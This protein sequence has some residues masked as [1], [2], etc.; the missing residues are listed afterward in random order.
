MEKNININVTANTSGVKTLRQELK[1]TVNQ[2]HQLEVGTDA[3]NTMAQKAADLKDQMQGV[4]EQINAL[5]TGSK[6]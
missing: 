4:N 2:L 3:F 5:T 1:E 6:Y